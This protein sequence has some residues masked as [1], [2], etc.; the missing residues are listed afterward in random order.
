MS[1]YQTLSGQLTLSDPLP[2]SAIRS[3]PFLPDSGKDTVFRYVLDV[4]RRDTDE[5]VLEVRRAVAVEPRRADESLSWRRSS[6][7]EELDLIWSEIVGYGV[8][9][10]IV[11][12]SDEHRAVAERWRPNG[13]LLENERATFRWPD[14]SEVEL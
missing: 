12:A 13:R 4:Q 7:V 2:W 14:G 9:G 11:L 6:V 1:H 8:V 10:E 5:G 3:S